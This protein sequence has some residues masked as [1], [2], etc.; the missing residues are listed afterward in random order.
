MLMGFTR[1]TL[2]FITPLVLFS[3]LTS[4]ATV[5]FRPAAEIDWRPLSAL[6]AVESGGVPFYCHGAYV[7]PPLRYDST[8]GLM[9]AEA[10]NALHVVDQSTTLTGDVILNQG[11][12]EIRSPRVIQDEATQ[13]AEIDGPLQLRDRGLL[14]TGEHATSNL[15]TG[16]G[17]V[18]QATFLLHESSFRGKAATLARNNLNQLFLDDTTFTRCDPGSNVWSMNSETLELRPDE[19]Y[20]TARNVTLRI[21]DVPVIYTP[22]LRFPLNDD[23]QSGFL[24]PSLGHDNDGGTDIIIPYYFNLAP[25]YDATYQLHSMWKRGL[26]H[27]LQARH[28]S[29]RTNNE[30]NLGFIR[31]DDEYDDRDLED[32]TTAGTNTGVVIP[33]FEKQDRWYINLRH[34]A[35]WSGKWATS[36]DYNAVSDIDYVD[37]IGGEFGSTSIDDFLNPVRGNLTEQRSATLTRLGTLSYQSGDFQSSLN[38]Q[39][40]QSLDPLG[41]EQYERLPNLTASW[42][43][44]LG[45]LESKMKFDYTFFDK[46]NTG[47][48]GPLATIGERAYTDVE[49]AWPFRK[50]W[51]FFEPSAGVI[52][53]KYQLD[54][55]PLT[56]R[57]NPEITTGRFSLDGGLYFDRFFSLKGQSLQQTLEP[58]VFYLNVENDDQN[59]LPQFDAGASTQSYSSLFR[60]NRFSGFDRI[61]D[62]EHISVGLTSR[63]LSEET[64]S[65]FLALSLGQIYYLK[66]RDVVFQPTAAD[67]P[68]ADESPLFAEARFKVGD[69][70][71]VSG[72]YEWEPDV[73]RSNRGTFALK[74]SDGLRRILNINYT[75]TA[76]EIQQPSL[77]TKSEESDVNLIWPI[78][79]HWSAIG[80]WNFGW[81]DNRTIEAFA[82][83]EYNDCCWKTRLVW[84]RFLKDPRNVTQ[85]IDDPTTPGGFIA[86][87]DLKTPSDVGIFFEFQ[88]KGLAMLGGRLDSF[89]EDAIPGYR[90]REDRIGL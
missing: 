74:Y 76:S 21:K 60:N 17:V 59:D 39:G 49:V 85:L 55:E 68:T 87:T 82:G 56:A 29:L 15:L 26:I 70:L 77:I 67:D 90:E 31:R 6:N 24:M 61:G 43:K 83:L 46:D 30:I 9:H 32:L 22:Y 4:A 14:L 71:S 38:V 13:I 37:D 3:S 80:R 84:R 57:S 11:T 27:D 16:E 42:S 33:E 86:V 65:E 28:M 12:Q 58:R 10:N 75:Y 51:G 23:R 36:I 45:P 41:A 52:H 47:L 54:D 48:T 5:D 50:I 88:L 44:D 73:N 64:G 2:H 89:L 20:G 40:F 35:S 7:E 62:A 63:F 78:T 1:P 34:Q 69:N 66:D 53:R 72:T 81:D 25:N 79:Q 19:G 18:D 8:T